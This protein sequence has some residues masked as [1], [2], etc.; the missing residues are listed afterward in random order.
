VRELA[1]EPRIR[2]FMR[3]LGEAARD[4]GECYLTG[5]ATAVSVDG[6]SPTLGVD[7]KLDPEHDE[8]LR[9]LPHIKD[10][11]GIN[12]ELASPGDF[13][14]LPEGWR[15]RSASAAQEG[16]LSFRHVDLYSQALAKVE[17]GH[18]QD[19]DDV[20]LMLSRG[21]IERERLGGF[22]SEIEPWLYRFPPIDLAD[23]RRSVEGFLA[24]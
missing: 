24:S 16:R 21:L 6:T 15:D 12:V 4:D 1:D 7:I 11:L 23:F 13:I 17:R 10:T 9:A 3:A 22:F 20:R 18:A 2:R 14:P 19:V 5:G 8:L